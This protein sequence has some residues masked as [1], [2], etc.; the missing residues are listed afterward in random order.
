MDTPSASDL[1]ERSSEP[2]FAIDG[3][4]RIVAWNDEAA[5]LWG[6]EAGTALGQHCY[7]LFSARTSD[8]RLLC[9]RNCTAAVCFQHDRPFSDACMM[10]VASTGATRSVRASSIV[11]PGPPLADVPKAIVFLSPL[12]VAQQVPVTATCLRVQALGPL[13]LEAGGQIIDWQRWPRRQAATLFKYLLT[14]RGKP[15]HREVLV[16]TLW[17]GIV[18]HIGLARLKVL[19]HTLRRCLEPHLPPGAVS[20]FV[21]TEGECYRLLTGP[22]LSVD[23]DR[24]TAL[25]H[26]G[27][28][29]LE[30]EWPE[31]A[32][33]AFEAAASLYRGDYLQE[34]P[35][36]DWL[37]PER[38]LLCEQ[39]V[40]LLMRLASLYAAA[41]NFHAAIAC[42]RKALALDSCR[43]NL[44]RLLMLCLWEAGQRSEAVRQYQVCREILDRELALPPLPETTD[45]LQQI[46]QD[47]PAAVPSPV[48]V[49]AS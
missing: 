14:H 9:G 31:G 2:A 11:L 36:C 8:D 20:S 15:V 44:H 6:V 46:L 40:M 25:S 19:I 43:E 37:A 28:R 22:H 16:E 5:L 38:E 7:A 48:L 23:I 12:D 32:T 42:C 35:Y 24:F 39:Y 4:Q 26:E 49:D 45:L 3:V 1:V 30:E 18:P 33:R 34:D 29:A 17:P 41:R 21:V 13:R 10:T 27:D 47:D